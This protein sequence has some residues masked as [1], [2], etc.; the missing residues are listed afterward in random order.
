MAKKGM[1]RPSQEENNKGQ[2]KKRKKHSTF[3]TRSKI[4]FRV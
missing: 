1:K 4:I 2:T 3:C